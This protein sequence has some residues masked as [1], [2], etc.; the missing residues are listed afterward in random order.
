MGKKKKAYHK[1]F[2]L[3]NTMHKNC[4]LSFFFSFFLSFFFLARWGGGG[5]GGGVGG[6]VGVKH[7]LM[8]EKKKKRIW[9]PLQCTSLTF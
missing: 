4:F 9:F 5:G 8:L 3:L 7:K 2:Y 6:E 1:L